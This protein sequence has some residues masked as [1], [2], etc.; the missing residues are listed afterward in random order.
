VV[1]VALST[2][3]LSAC[4]P[5]HTAASGSPSNDA[6]SIRYVALVQHFWTAYIAA[7]N[8]GP[9]PNAAVACVQVPDLKACSERV[10]EMLP[11]LELFLG[12]LGRSVAPAKYAKDDAELRTQLPVAIAD[13]TMVLK[14]AL[15]GESGAFS[16]YVNAYID[17]MVPGVTSAL[18]DVD[19]SKVHT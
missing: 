18:D 11:T 17:D 13:L 8:D 2:C 14:T 6:A 5:G 7:E 1:V 9:P 12:D 16:T 3:F 15:A 10:R 4:G 19:P